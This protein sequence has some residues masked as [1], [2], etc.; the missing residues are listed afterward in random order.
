MINII[1]TEELAVRDK[2]N[3]MLTGELRRVEQERR[4]AELAGIQAQK[5]SL[6]RQ[7]YLLGAVPGHSIRQ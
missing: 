7:R 4:H 1:H 3:I 2:E 5:E 6:A